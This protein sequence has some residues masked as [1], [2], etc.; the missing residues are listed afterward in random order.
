[1]LQRIAFYSRFSYDKYSNLKRV[2]KYITIRVII[3]TRLSTVDIRLSVT[4][5][6]FVNGRKT[7]LF[8]DGIRLLVCHSLPGKMYTVSARAVNS[9]R[10]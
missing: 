7:V 10:V 8:L 5:T 6:G 9:D 3:V 1:M 4:T 2:G